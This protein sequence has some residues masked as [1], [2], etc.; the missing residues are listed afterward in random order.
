MNITEDSGPQPE[1]SGPHAGGTDPHAGGSASR[2]EGLGPDLEAPGPFTEA[3]GLHAK[4]PGPVSPALMLSDRAGEESFQRHAVATMN[5]PLALALESLDAI[6]TPDLTLPGAGADTKFAASE[7]PAQQKAPGMSKP[8]AQPETPAQPATADGPDEP[9]ESAQPDAPTTPD[10]SA[11]SR[12]PSQP[13]EPTEREHKPTAAAQT[14]REEILDGA[15]RLF[16]ER[17]YHGSSLRDIS[18]EVG[19][20]HPGM[21]HHFA[22]KDTLLGAVIDRME[23]HA[24]DLLDGTERI[25][26]SEASLDAALGGPWNPKNHQ[27]GLL[28]TLASEVV[29]PKHPGRYRV[30]RLRLVHEHVLESVLESFAA[31]GELTDDADCAFVARSTVSLLLS[32]AVRE[33]SV[34]ALQRTES[35]EPVR[36]VHAFVRHYIAT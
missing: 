29:N 9:A 5:D 11:D 2:S 32:L 36:D 25:A 4:G 16:A 21:L 6:A 7:A 30:A 8:P 15:S 23:D 1:D 24:Q 34:R 35:A 10:E 3:P 14:R 13:A 27:M 20:S 33:R 12:A 31:R 18:R 19:I 22:S 17:G 28:A 26:A